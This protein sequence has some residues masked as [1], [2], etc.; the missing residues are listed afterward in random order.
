M[1]L[2]GSLYFIKSMSNITLYFSDN[3]YL[4]HFL[5]TNYMK[6]LNKI[7]LIWG[8]TRKIYWIFSWDLVPKEWSDPELGKVRCFCQSSLEGL[9]S[10]L[11]LEQGY[12]FSLCSSTFPY[13]SSIPPLYEISLFSLLHQ[14]HFIL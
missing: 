2:K 6:H 12:Y 14:Y 11:P 8:N 4:Y 7:S 5:D 10:S 3:K 9:N 1:V 13:W